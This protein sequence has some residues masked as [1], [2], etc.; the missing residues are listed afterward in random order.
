MLKRSLPC[1]WIQS[2][3]NNIIDR[4]TAAFKGTDVRQGRGE[5]TGVDRDMLEV[6]VILNV[7]LN[8]R[9]EGSK[10]VGEFLVRQSIEEELVEL[11]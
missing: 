5:C 7:L 11:D 6:I 8:E 4:E 1:F 10:L 9:F 2:Q 3:P